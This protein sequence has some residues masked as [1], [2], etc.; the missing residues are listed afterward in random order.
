[1]VAALGEWQQDLA[2]KAADPEFVPPLREVRLTDLEA[3]FVSR[4]VPGLD[5]FFLC[6]RRECLFVCRNIDWIEETGGNH[7]ACPRCGHQYRPW[8]QKAHMVTANKVLVCQVADDGLLVQGQL[9]PAASGSPEASAA[10]APAGSASGS[11]EASPAGPAPVPHFRFEGVVCQPGSYLV[12]PIV[13]A[14]TTTT[15]LMNAFKAIMLD[16]DK[17]L[18][19]LPPKQRIN[20]VIEKVAWGGHP[21]MFVHQRLT[22]DVVEHIDHIN[23]CRGGVNKQWSY[24]H[25]RNGFYGAHLPVQQMAEVFSQT[26]LIRMWGLATWL[27]AQAN[28]AA[29]PWLEARVTST[30]Q[31]VTLGP[32]PQ[33]AAP[34]R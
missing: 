26:D 11:P 8:V 20:Y 27:E 21:N 33:P 9:P 24:E 6:R 12:F 2:A 18:A 31:R 4:I 30:G 13:W 28:A 14:E 7:F 3:Q 16:L 10:A 25:I 1:M 5:E 23:M 17:Q 29:A 34:G 15:N 32:A 19:A 22:P